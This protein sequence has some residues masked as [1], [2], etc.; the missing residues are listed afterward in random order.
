MLNANIW[1]HTIK[2]NYK[3]IFIFHE[4]VK[5]DAQYSWAWK[6]FI[7]SGPGLLFSG[8]LIVMP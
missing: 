8:S 6:S 1:E 4:Q 5:F 3:C 2:K 7:T